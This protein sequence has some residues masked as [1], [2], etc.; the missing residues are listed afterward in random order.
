MEGVYDDFFLF[1][2]S[3]S[4][5][6]SSLTL[7]SSCES[8]ISSSCLLPALLISTTSSTSS[9]GA[10]IWQRHEASEGRPVPAFWPRI[11]LVYM[12]EDTAVPRHT[13]HAAP[14]AT[15]KCYYVLCLFTS[16][17]SVCGV[18]CEYYY[19]SFSNSHSSFNLLNLPCHLLLYR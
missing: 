2:F 12:Q 15:G 18:Q 1:L 3:C 16:L 8:V 17:S 11:P 10:W 14:H 5:S 9:E 19:V 4:L 6:S 13:L 7:L